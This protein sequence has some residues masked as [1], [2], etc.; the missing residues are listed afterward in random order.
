MPETTPRGYPYPLYT[1][2]ADF[3]AQLQDLAEAVDTDIEALFN[4]LTAGLNMAACRV[5][6]SLVNQNIP[7]STDQI[8][9]YTTEVYDNA[10]M[11]SLGTSNTTM[12]FTQTG[13]Y[14][15][16][17]RSTF[18]P[19]G[20][21]TVNARQISL[22]SSGTM[23]V[24]GRRAVQGSQTEATAVALTVPP[25]FAAAGDTLTMIQRQ[26]SGAALNSSTRSLM[27]ARIGAL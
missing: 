22:V 26:N 23:G 27:V 15:A 5:Q 11:F 17:G 2:T 10:G 12:T 3:P 9:S 4:R 18:Q 1:D 13:L 25:F 8:A 24:L 14:I 6:A 19:N 21:A 16:M 20:N 7:V